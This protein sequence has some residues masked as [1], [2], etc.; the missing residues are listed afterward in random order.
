[1]TDSSA[2]LGLP[3]IL[4]G[5][6]QKEVTHNEAL[7]RLDAAV[8]LSVLDRDLTS[9][10][11]SP[12]EGSVYLV[13][14]GAT[15]L[16]SGKDGQIVACYNGWQVL[17][18]REGWLAWVTDEEVLLRHTGSGWT[19]FA[20]T[21]GQ[22]LMA[23]QDDASI[24]ALLGQGSAAMLTAGTAAGNAVQLDGNARLP[25]VDGSQL[26]NMPTPTRLVHSFAYGDAT[27]AMVGTLPAGAVISAV[28]LIILTAFNGVSPALAVGDDGNDSRFMTAEQNDAGEAVAYTTSPGEKLSAAVTVR[29]SIQPG[30][31]ATAGSGLLIVDYA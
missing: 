14:T 6:A 11:A 23:A 17:A 9:P 25:A 8:Q 3:Y 16:W 30:T 5:Q 28:T 7:N 24:R 31:G 1:M 12:A 29:L 20:S 19:V 4:T 27:P 18:P 10:P 2:R 15:G 13:A 26:L 21:L 22:S